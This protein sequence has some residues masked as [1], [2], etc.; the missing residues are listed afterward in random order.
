MESELFQYNNW[1]CFFKKHEH[2]IFQAVTDNQTLMNCMEKFGKPVILAAH[3]CLIQ[4]NTG[5]CNVFLSSP[6]LA[7]QN[8]YMVLS[9][10]N[11]LS[12]NT[13]T[14]EKTKSSYTQET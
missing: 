8:F 4:E 13:C 2:I 11:T 14:P 10:H 7:T 12:A 9:K 5:L 3:M 6:E 1:T